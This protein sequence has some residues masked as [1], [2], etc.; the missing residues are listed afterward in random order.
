MRLRRFDEAHAFVERAQPFLLEHEAENCL[1]LG[2]C[3][4]LMRQP[5]FY[6]TRPYL[7]CIEGDDEA[8]AL[9]VLRNPPHFPV[10]SLPAPH[11]AEAAVGEALALLLTDLRTTYGGL[12][13]IHGPSALSRAFA[14]RWSAATGQDC[15]PSMAERFYQLDAVIPVTG[16]AGT[17][18]RATEADRALL[19]RWIEE[20]RAEAIPPSEPRMPADE[21]VTRMLSDPTMRG[22]YLWED[23]GVSVTMA[24]YSGPTAHGMRIGPVYTP[25]AHRAHGY[26]SACT[27]AL[28]QT[29]LDGGR[30]FVFLSADLTN[31]TSNHIYQQIGYRPVCDVTVYDFE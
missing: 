27:A 24:G 6:A 5:D 25:I 9:V 7:A 15:R 10:L 17:L 23:G 11:L 2:M 1:L 22:I 18:R 13:G 12:P 31:P 3:A 8:V 19:E 14:E 16:V 29:L 26:A 30:R 20:F 28:S 4:T 21:L